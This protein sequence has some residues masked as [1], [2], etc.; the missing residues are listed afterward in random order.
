MPISKKTF[1]KKRVKKSV[2]KNIRKHKKR[3]LGRKHRKSGKRFR[4]FGGNPQRYIIQLQGNHPDNGNYFLNNSD[5]IREMGNEMGIEIDNNDIPIVMNDVSEQLKQLILHIVNNQFSLQLQQN[6]INV[7]VDGNHL[8]IQ[9]QPDL[10]QY[11][12]DT[13]IR[14]GLP[15]FINEISFSRMTNLANDM[16]GEAQDTLIPP[17]ENLSIRGNEE[18][19]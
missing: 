4:F 7:I 13:V 17:M 8:V 14:S 9:V 3:T 12:D 15:N 11:I 6:D 18:R 2:K 10:D 16:D 5:M 1:S 19:P